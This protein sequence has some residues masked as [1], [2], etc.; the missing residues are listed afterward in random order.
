MRAA[1]IGG[2][3]ADGELMRSAYARRADDDDFRQAGELVRRIFSDAQR[4]RLVRTLI[5]QYRQLRHVE[6]RE[7]FLSYWNNI[8]PETAA[9]IRDAVES[10]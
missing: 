2:W 9:R 8:D 1:E 6:I 4:S 10:T 3:R 7:R 5:G